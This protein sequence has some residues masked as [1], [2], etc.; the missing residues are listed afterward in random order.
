MVYSAFH[1]CWQYRLFLCNLKPQSFIQIHFTKA[2]CPSILQSFLFATWPWGNF[3]TGAG[4]G[5][6]MHLC[7]SGF[8]FTCL[9]FHQTSFK[10]VTSIQ[11]F[12]Q[13][14]H[15]CDLMN[16]TWSQFRVNVVPMPFIMCVVTVLC[17]CLALL[18][19]SHLNKI[20]MFKRGDFNLL[21]VYNMQYFRLFYNL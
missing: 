7:L 12:E 17:S 9:L 18:A 11:V 6:F 4:L 15:Q 19:L 20:R 8:T 2:N 16:C 10:T 3:A 1:H 5:G 13:L 14:N 21:C